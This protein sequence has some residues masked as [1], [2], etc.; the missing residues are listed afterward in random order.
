[1]SVSRESECRKEKNVRNDTLSYDSCRCAGRRERRKR[2]DGGERERERDR[3]MWMKKKRK[4]AG[5]FAGHPAVTQG[6]AVVDAEDRKSV[7]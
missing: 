5:V 3:G 1:M 2:K 6:K 7:V 4:K